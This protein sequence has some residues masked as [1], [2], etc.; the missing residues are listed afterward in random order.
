VHVAQPGDRPPEPAGADA[1]KRLCDRLT[2]LQRKVLRDVEHFERLG[3]DDQHRL[4][5]RLKRLRYVAALIGPLFA[6]RRVGAWMSHVKPAQEALGRHVDLLIAARRFREMA[7]HEPRA[8][9][10]A[11]WL[12]ARSCET[13]LECRS[14]LERL[15]RADVFW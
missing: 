12:Q 10:A 8:W 5:K 7:V 1:L 9:F 15:Q 14:C 11:G 2:R 4:R 6:S 3:F 13:A